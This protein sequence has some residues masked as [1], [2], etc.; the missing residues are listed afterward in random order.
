M[1]VSFGKFKNQEIDT[2]PSSYLKWLAE[3]IDD[4]D[5]GERS[6]CLAADEEYQERERTGC[7]FETASTDDEDR[8]KCP[9]CGKVFKP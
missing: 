5:K 1:Q 2:L 9:H 3:N 4:E 8:V 7:H 6:I